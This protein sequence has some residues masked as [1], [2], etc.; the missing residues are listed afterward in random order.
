MGVNSHN[1]STGIRALLAASSKFEHYA[2]KL[3]MILNGQKKRNPE[4]YICSNIDVSHANAFDT[5]TTT[6]IYKRELEVI[7]Q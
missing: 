2:Q 7:R 1:I 4:I 6:K 5:D 3:A